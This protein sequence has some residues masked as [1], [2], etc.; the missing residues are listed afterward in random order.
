MA[1]TIGTPVPGT[2]TLA[3]FLDMVYANRDVSLP[4]SSAVFT[5]LEVNRIVVN[6][7]GDDV[8]YITFAARP[9]APTLINY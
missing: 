7:G 6:W 9:T 3:A 1:L 5:P 4:S 8:I 2:T